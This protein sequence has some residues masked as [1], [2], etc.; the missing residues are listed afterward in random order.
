[1]MT[2]HVS[3]NTPLSEGA[4]AKSDSNALPLIE[5]HVVAPRVVEPRCLRRGLGRDGGGLFERATVLEIGRDSPR[6][7]CVV[8]DFGPDIGRCRA[9]LQWE[10]GDSLLNPIWGRS[11]KKNRQFL[12]KPAKT[13]YCF[14]EISISSTRTVRGATR[15]RGFGVKTG[16]DS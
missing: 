10:Y 16:S 7:E 8:A 14:S 13:W 4:R 6:P 5:A 2:S 11:D 3:M 15:E 9:E 12:A 1:M